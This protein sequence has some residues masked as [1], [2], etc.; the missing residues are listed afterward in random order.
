MYIINF[1][2]RITFLIHGSE[3]RESKNR[4]DNVA[5]KANYYLQHMRNSWTLVLLTQ[6]SGNGAKV[7]FTSGLLC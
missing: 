7:V 5:K 1:I 4:R 6:K 2:L 3:G